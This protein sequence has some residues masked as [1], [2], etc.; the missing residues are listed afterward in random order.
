MF[1][2]HRQLDATL[3]AFGTAIAKYPTLSLDMVLPD[4]DI[5]QPICWPWLSLQL[6]RHARR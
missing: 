1:P 2:S 4:A 5:K 6:L 3:V